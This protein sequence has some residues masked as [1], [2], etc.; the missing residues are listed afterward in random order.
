[1]NNPIDYWYQ[2]YL[3]EKS[4][5]EQLI[6]KACK[7]LDKNAMKYLEYDISEECDCLNIIRLVEDF[8]K[9]N[10]GIKYG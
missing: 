9:S 7:W 10:G 3:K 4:K 2:K 6:E 5:N 8:K 1:M